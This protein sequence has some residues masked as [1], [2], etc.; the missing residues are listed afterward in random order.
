MGLLTIS[1]V[2]EPSDFRKQLLGLAIAV[3]PLVG[4]WFTGRDRLYRATPWL[5]A[6]A[7]LLQLATIL[8]GKEVNGSKNWLVIGPLQFQPLEL[9]KLSLILMLARI[10]KDGYR[11]LSS[12]ALPLAIALPVMALVAKEDFG[13]AMV[14]G[15][16]VACMLLTWKMPIWHFWAVVVVIGVAFPTVIFSQ[17]KPYQQARLTVFLDPLKDARG[18]GYQLNQSIIAIGSGGI[19][20]KGYK[21]GTQSHKGFVFS[22]HSDFVFAS[23]AEEQG[24]VGAVALLGLFALV[25]WRLAAMGGESPQLQDKLV[26]AG[27][28]G[29]LGVQALENIGAAMSLLPL[30]GITLPLV[31]YGLSSLVA[32]LTTLGVVYVVYRDRYQGTF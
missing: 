24:F 29:Q 13:G 12:Y 25:F 9:L 14:L 8:I 28:L 18:S 4:L 27:V 32:V 16:I 5:F 11:N 19:K 15:G 23:L 6:I 20:G 31:S 3:V 1:S 17:L 21:E 7:V 22:Q 10:L 30:T 2:A 26:I